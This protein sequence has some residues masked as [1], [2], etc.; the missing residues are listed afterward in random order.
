MLNDHQ[1][2]KIIMNRITKQLICSASLLLA[3]NVHAAI[4]NNNTQSEQG[5]SANQPTELNTTNTNNQMGGNI[6][7]NRSD[8]AALPNKQ[9]QNT[10]VGSGATIIGSHNIG[11]GSTTTVAA[12]SIA[13]GNTSDAK[14]NSTAIGTSAQAE[15]N[16]VALGRQSY[17]N[18]SI[19][20]GAHAYATNNSIAIGNG[21]RADEKDTVSF[22]GKVYSQQYVDG[23]VQVT[24]TDVT[25]RLTNVH[26]G[27]NATDAVNVSQLTEAKNT[28]QGEITH[29][30][31]NISNNSSEITRNSNNIKTN[32]VNIEQNNKA[33]DINKNIIA[34]NANNIGINKEN[35]NKNITNIQ[36]NTQNITTNSKQISQ[37]TSDINDN[38][39]VII[40]N[41]NDIQKNR[42]DILNNTTIANKNSQRISNNSQSIEKNTAGV[43]TNA[44]NI[45]HLHNESINYTNNHVMAYYNKSKQYTDE[46]AQ[47]TLQKA[48]NYTDQRVNQLSNVF[49]EKLKNLQNREDA[50]IASA[51]AMAAITVKPNRKYNIGMGLGY[52]GDQD[53][54]ALAA[55]INTSPD[56]IVTLDTSYNSNHNVGVAAGMTFGFN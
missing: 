30:S 41:G 31:Q 6:I 46:K 27:I 52:Y 45:S 10:V 17:A 3:C 53:A 7:I 18:N 21:S 15:N 19:A 49:N 56:S 43:N 38:K 50:G 23:K 42:K 39:R 22:G 35:I 36:N 20:L 54:I 33:I 5:I 34:N 2:L 55:K 16:G 24:T 28:L 40:N 9:Y 11:L 8:T 47:Q 14:D 32:M 12:N 48:N 4:V 25:R 29:N 13:I 26:A 37:N 1:T 51:M 44:Y